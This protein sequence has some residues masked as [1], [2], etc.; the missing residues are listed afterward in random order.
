MD[1]RS[2]LK[3]GLFG[4]ALLALGGGGTLALLPT[5]A[6]A[7][8]TRPLAVLGE[9]GFQVLVAIARRVVPVEGADHVAIVHA[10]DDALRLAAPEAQKD[11]RDLL[12]LFEN[13]LP[14]ALLDRRVMPF[15]RLDPEAQDR[16]LEAWRDSRL[17]LRRGGYHALRKLCV[18]PYYADP[19]SWRG[20]RYP[21]PPMVAGLVIDDSRAGA[22][23]RSA[24]ANLPAKAGVP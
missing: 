4:G 16:V 10:A 21:G 23:E 22:P 12:G 8:P 18:A 2:F 1:R 11:L 9:R 17:T 6:V 24:P 14:G 3:K 20:V 7:A 15:T 13:A 19:S 5:R